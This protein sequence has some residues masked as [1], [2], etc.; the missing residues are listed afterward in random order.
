MVLLQQ[1]H[2]IFC[3][4]KIYIRPLIF[5]LFL[6]PRWISCVRPPMLGIRHQLIQMHCTCKVFFAVLRVASVSCWLHILCQQLLFLLVVSIA[7]SSVIFFGLFLF[8][9]C[10]NSHPIVHGVLFCG[11]RDLSMD[12]L[13]MF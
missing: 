6:Q 8:F 2:L 12:R 3:V 11:V 7:V 13:T 1:Q 4:P 5:F 10:S 9:D